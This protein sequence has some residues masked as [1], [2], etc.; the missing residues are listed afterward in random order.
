MATLW[1]D[2]TYN[3]GMKKPI[4]KSQPS[5]PP[6]SSKLRLATL[7]ALLVIVW[8]VFQWNGGV[9]GW[10]NSTARQALAGRRLSDAQRW[11]G[12]AKSLSSTNAES[13]FLLARLARKQG[14][15]PVMA[16]H[17]HA[18]SELG[19]E[20]KQL[21][22]EQDLA[23]AAM[24]RLEDG[25]EERLQTWLQEGTLDYSE[26]ADA[27]TNGLTALSRFDEAQALLQAWQQSDPKEPVINYRQ[28][29]IHEHF[30]QPNLAEEEYRKAIAKDSTFIKPK[31]H[32]A[33]LLLQIRQPEEAL[34]LF[35]ACDV[36]PTALAAQT[37]VAGCYRNQGEAEKARDTLDRVMQHSFEEVM[38]SYRSVDEAIERYMPASELGCIQTELGDFEHA[39]K[40]LE[41]AL[42]KFPRD[43]IARYSYG[44]TLRSLG[45]AKEAEE[46]FERTRQ[47]RTALDEVSALQEEL[48]K[49]ATNTDARLKIGKIVLEHESEHTGVFWIQSVFSYDP[50]N[51]AAHKALV[52]YY[53]SKARPTDEDRKL[54]D[55]HRAFLRK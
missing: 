19:Y 44:V 1:A 52:D 55:Y 35:L 38:E 42:D 51:A 8:F 37:G 53:E 31:Y 33:R 45:F 26:V 47:A 12:R 40:N 15:L 21:A 2:R 48:R 32:L 17:L 9:A 49:D 29:R 7:F 50:E 16:E 3:T 27:Y 34:A 25:V 4:E 10:M 28:G 54:A 11:L 22:R 13:E 14:Q 20:K 24:G 36:G 41:L 6:K 5:P 23:L 39:R 43:T 30:R 18:A 46:H